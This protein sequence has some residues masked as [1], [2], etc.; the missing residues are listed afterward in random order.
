MNDKTKETTNMSPFTPTPQLARA[1]YCAGA[2]QH[3]GLDPARLPHEQHE[4]IH[5]EFDRMLA[6]ERRAAG[7]KAL[8]DAA[9]AHEQEFGERAPG[10]T[11]S[12]P[13]S[14]WLRGHAERN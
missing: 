13:A 11:L 4:R 12:T 14:R 3:D 8:R 2:A 9:D 10:V 7:A 1:W 6:E 5:G